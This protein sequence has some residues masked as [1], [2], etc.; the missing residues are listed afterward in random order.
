MGGETGQNKHKQMW[1]GREIGIIDL[2]PSPVHQD[3]MQ[4]CHAVE[5]T[6]YTTNTIIHPRLSNLQL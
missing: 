5:W 3:S 2:P 6:N 4:I 1:E